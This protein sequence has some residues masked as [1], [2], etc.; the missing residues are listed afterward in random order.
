[1]LSVHPDALPES[2][3]LFDHLLLHIDAGVLRLPSPLQEASPGQSINDLSSQ[4]GPQASLHGPQA[5]LNFSLAGTPNERV[6]VGVLKNCSVHDG[7][8]T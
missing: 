8:L 5:Q 2:A 6:S 3:C 4:D 7:Q 1:M